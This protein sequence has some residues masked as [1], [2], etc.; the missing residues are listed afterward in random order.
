MVGEH[1]DSIRINGQSFPV[2]ERMR[3]AGRSLLVIEQLGHFS[4]PTYRVVEPGLTH[5]VR[6]LQILPYSKQT[7]SR[8]RL[9]SKISKPQ[10]N[11]PSIVS[12]HRNADQVYLLTQWIDGPTLREYHRQCQSGREP[13][14]S[15]LV[16]IN[17]MLGLAHGFRLLHDRLG[18]VHG[19]LHPAN[20]VLCRHT[21]RLVP[22][23]FGSA[24]PV[25]R[26]VMTSKT[27]QAARNY[28]APEVLDQE[29]IGFQ[30]DQF[31]AMAVCYQMLTG[32]VPYDGLGGRAALASTA[33]RGVDELAIALTPPSQQLRHSASIPVDSK[34]KLDALISRGL[35]FTAEERFATTRQFID[36][37]REVRQ[38][39][40]AEAA[41]PSGLNQ[42]L[43]R[44]ISE[45][46]GWLRI[47]KR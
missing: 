33:D 30:S 44:R 18:V 6:C 32:E 8:I 41:G 24:F 11:L 7:A 40:A 43:L 14:P 17:L 38:L 27:H 21:K 31:S 12:S 1:R 19:D 25:E 37:L 47:D 45:A 26:S 10:A 28:A 16:T 29:R 9:L 34:S 2:L 36:A 42:W 4:R 3:V 20:L 22:I 13:W 35:A 5:E 39:L 15:A 46:A 23:D